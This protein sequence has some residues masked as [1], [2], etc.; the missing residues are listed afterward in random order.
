MLNILFVNNVGG[1]DFVLN[2]GHLF[3]DSSGIEPLTLQGLREKLMVPPQIA[4]RAFQC[5]Y[6]STILNFLGNCV[7]PW[8]TEVTISP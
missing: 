8:V 7:P 2:A 5:Q 1:I 6:V 3:V 4:S